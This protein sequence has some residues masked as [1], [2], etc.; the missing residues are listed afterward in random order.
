[1][2]PQDPQTTH[3]ES[4]QVF[5]GI[6]DTDNHESRGTG[7]RART[8]GQ[9]LQEA[10]LGALRHI[11]RH[12]LLVDPRIPYT[13]H[14]SAACLTLDVADHTI[15]Q[16]A[17]FCSTFLAQESAP[18][19]DAGLC[20][21][22]ATQI[23]GPVRAFGARAKADLVKHE[24]AHLLAR[25]EGLWLE[26]ITGDH[27]GVIGA[28]AAVGLRASGNDGRFIW[29]LGLRELQGIQTAGWLLKTTG[30]EHIR[31]VEGSAIP[32]EARVNVEPWPRPILLEGQAV[33]LVRKAAPTQVA[34][35]W[36]LLS[37]EEIRKY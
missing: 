18:G 29:A 37:K 28:L 9:A 35:D 27:G 17:A 20:I 30:I 34:C 14:N 21:G 26:G 31:T 19:S 1:M 15:A 10:G 33:L 8:L 4:R 24:T 6:D 11:T 12:Q 7:F 3:V 23:N 32:G 5:I 13:T 16:L 25:R 22:K 36:E 2:K